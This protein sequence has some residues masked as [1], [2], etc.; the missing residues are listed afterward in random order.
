MS[1]ASTG[2]AVTLPDAGG[3]QYSANSVSGS[4]GTALAQLSS[5][6][7]SEPTSACGSFSVQRAGVDGVNAISQA[8]GHGRVIGISGD[9]ILGGSMGSFSAKK[10]APPVSLLSIP[11]STIS[12]LHTNAFAGIGG[13]LEGSRHNNVVADAT[14]SDSPA[15]TALSLGRSLRDDEDF[16]LCPDGCTLFAEAMRIGNYRYMGS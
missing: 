9:G 16:T 12:M 13:S 3:E 14:M 5:P 7:V 15:L 8:T 11:E 2:T 10:D 4:S 1:S 6:M